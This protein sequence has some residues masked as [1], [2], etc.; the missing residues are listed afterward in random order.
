[1]NPNPLRGLYCPPVIPAKLCQARVVFRDGSWQVGLTWAQQDWDQPWGLSFTSAKVGPGL[2][3]DW[4][5]FTVNCKKIMWDCT[6]N[7]TCKFKHHINVTTCDITSSFNQPQPQPNNTT[8]SN[9]DTT[10]NANNNPR[11]PR[12]HDRPKNEDDRPQMKTAAHKRQWTPTRTNDC[13]AHERQPGPTN[14]HRRRLPQVSKITP[15]HYAI[16]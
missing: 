10:P 11:T 8:N 15:P 2:D 7:L 13:L 6:C 1:M 5:V 12:H 3:Q 4:G 16:H 9:H 14:G